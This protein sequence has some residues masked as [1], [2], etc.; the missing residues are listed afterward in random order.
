M[1]VLDADTSQLPFIDAEHQVASPRSNF[2][3]VM[4]ITPVG[5]SDGMKATVRL[6]ESVVPDPESN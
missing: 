5:A 2:V 1:A 4:P 6:L 3:P